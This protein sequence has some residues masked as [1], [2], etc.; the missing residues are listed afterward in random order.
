MDFLYSLGLSWIE[1]LCIYTLPGLLYSTHHLYQEYR[2]RPS[3]FA[4]D[5]LKAI[6]Q[7]KS[8][9]DRLLNIVVYIIAIAAMAFVWPAFLVWG[10]VKRKEEAAREIERNKP[11]F[12]CSPQYLVAKVDP[13]DAET[14]NYVIDPLSKLAAVP[15]GHLNKGWGNFLADMT[16]EEDE[17]WSFFIPKGSLC[18]QY[19]SASTSD[20]R[21]YAKVRRGEILDEFI[22]ESD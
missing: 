10:L 16:D 15:F 2:T 20:I 12:E 7:E 14:A 11:R 22:T 17:M 6:G 21:G 3:Q 5:M 19:R 1:W 8:I 9:T 4:R 18:G 13:I